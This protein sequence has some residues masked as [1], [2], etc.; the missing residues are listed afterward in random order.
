MYPKSPTFTK[1]T[2]IQKLLQQQLWVKQYFLL[3]FYI[4]LLIEVYLN[5]R[6]FIFFVVQLMNKT[7]GYHLDLLQEILKI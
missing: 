1:I 5:M 2:K 3:H 4:D 7:N 6:K